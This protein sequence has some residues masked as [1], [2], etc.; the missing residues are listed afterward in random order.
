MIDFNGSLGKVLA[1][2]LLGVA[3]ME[4]DIRKERQ[5]VGIAAAKAK[6]L[7]AK[8]LTPDEIAKVNDFW[9][10]LPANAR[11]RPALSVLAIDDRW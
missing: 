3:E 7:R 9:Y 11:N 5:A 10:T 1:A 2:V 8:G 4:H 6:A